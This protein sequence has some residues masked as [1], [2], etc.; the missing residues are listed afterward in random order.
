[1]TTFSPK[2]I[3]LFI[4]LKTTLFYLLAYFWLQISQNWAVWFKTIKT[5]K[6]KKKTTT[7]ENKK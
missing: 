7:T 4:Y 2:E 5:N 6:Y 1:M 3:I